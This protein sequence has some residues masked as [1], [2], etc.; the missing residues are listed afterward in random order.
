MLN[1]V[2]HARRAA[3]MGRDSLTA[4]ED[5][6]NTGWRCDSGGLTALLILALIGA[7]GLSKAVIAGAG[8]LDQGFGSGGIVTT[9]FLGGIDQA[10]SIAI[11]ADGRGGA[12]RAHG[13]PPH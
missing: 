10:F 12:P 1:R 7:A 9:D 5:R 8:Q 3:A 4:R 2:N 11:Q 6:F 13:G